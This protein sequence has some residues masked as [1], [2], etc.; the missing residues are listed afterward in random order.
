[1]SLRLAPPIDH[2]AVSILARASKLL[3]A[4]QKNNPE[5]ERADILREALLIGLD[6]LEM[7]YNI[8]NL[9]QISEGEE[10]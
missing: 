2:R 10:Q 1:M 4:K 8:D 3:A 5:L 9:G 7:E 6:M